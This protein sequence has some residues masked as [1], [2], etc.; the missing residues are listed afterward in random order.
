MN[1]YIPHRKMLILFSS[2]L[3]PA[4]GQDINATLRGTV[5]D[6]SGAVIAGAAVKITSNE[7]GISRSIATNGAG[8]YVVAEL[9]PESYSVSAAA[10]G[11]QTQTRKDFVLQVGQEA[12]LDFTLQVGQ[13]S[14]SVEVTGSA[15]LIQSED[16]SIG[17]VV[18]E[19]KVKELPLNGRNA[20]T[21]A[22]LAA[23]AFGA[24]ARQDGMRADLEKMRDSFVCERAHRRRETHGRAHMREPIIGAADFIRF[25]KRPRYVRNEGDAQRREPHRVEC[26]SK[27]RE[28]RLDEVGVRRK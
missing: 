5:H 8:D 1:R 15:P 10:A 14:E 6:S 2:L 16:H 12:R 28:H 18:D 11:F 21:L 17:D 4:F 25:D 24:H 20:F 9:A 13:A 23:N 27:R 3:A 7:R 22:L 19:K 26:P